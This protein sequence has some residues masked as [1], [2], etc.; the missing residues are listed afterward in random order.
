[1]KYLLD[2]N[3]LVALGFIHHEFHDRMAAWIKAQRF[4][5]L[6]T[7]S[8]TELGFVRALSQAPAYGF[9]VVQARTALLRLKRAKILTFAFITD[10]HDISIFPRRLRVPGRPRMVT[11][12]SLQG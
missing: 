1:V 2:V 5:E 6:A 11:W 7:C 4:P 8:I 10:A 12:W 9:T 3:V